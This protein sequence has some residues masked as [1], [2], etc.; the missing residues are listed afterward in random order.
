MISGA[1]VEEVAL[2]L[3]LR[4]DADDSGTAVRRELAALGVDG[5]PTVIAALEFVQLWGP[6]PEHQAAE[7][8][9]A[10]LFLAGLITGLR[11]A[12]KDGRAVA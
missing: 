11:V 10:S 9:A 8:H 3:M 6:G 2:D 4:V 1:L 12:Q 7:V 5:V